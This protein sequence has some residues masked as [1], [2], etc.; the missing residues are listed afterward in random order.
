MQDLL[1]DRSMGDKT[2]PVGNQILEQPLRVGLVRMSGADEIH[3]E[4]RINQNQVCLP[5]P[6]PL[7]ISANIASISPEG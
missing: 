3:G 6:Y 2:L 7:S 5:A 1:Q 4:I